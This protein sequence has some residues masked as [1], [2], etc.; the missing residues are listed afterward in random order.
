M[1]SERYGASVTWTPS[2]LDLLNA[3]QELSI[4]VRRADGS[5]RRWTP[6]WVVTFDGQV[7]VRS[8]YRRETG[9]FGAALRSLQAR[10]RVP[11]LEVDVLIED[12]GGDQEAGV[13]SAY[14]SKYGGSSVDA[15]VSAEAVATTLRL[16]PLG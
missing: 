8:W 10:V 9:W 2:Q 13:T 6:V 7:Y 16:L 5:L 14:R 12:A 3:A 1:L 11:G 4:A 15:M